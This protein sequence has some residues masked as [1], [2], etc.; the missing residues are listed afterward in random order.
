MTPLQHENEVMFARREIERAAIADVTLEALCVRHSRT[1]LPSRAEA[2]P[3]IAKE[4]R[5]FVQQRFPAALIRVGE[6]EGN[7]LGLAMPGP[8]HFVQLNCFN[9]TFSAQTGIALLEAEA[10][11]FGGMIREALMSADI[12]GFRAFGRDSRPN[13]ELEQIPNLISRGDIRGALGMLYAR[14]FLEAALARGNFRDKILT[15][16]WIHLA[17]IPHLVEILSVPSSV[18]VITGKTE[19][20]DHFQ[21]R[22]GKR[23]RSFIAVPDE[24]SPISSDADSHYRKIF[25]QV[26]NALKNDLHGTLVL[27]GAGLF[28]KIYCHIAKQN[29]AVALD[30]GSAF[31][32]L[33]GKKT[34]PVHSKLDIDSLRWM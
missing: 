12:I 5:K 31:D 20:K 28:G 13:S 23:L 15:S 10:R 14:E 26:I 29:G 24:G 18:I 34:R 2:A 7:A 9:A 19:L 4:I 3:T 21:R 22:L 32:I 16:A 6:G 25:P 1:F 17:L 11:I 27:V 30:L 33:A 8:L